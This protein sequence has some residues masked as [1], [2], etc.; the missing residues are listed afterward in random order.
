MIHH[1]THGIGKIVCAT[2]P[3][4]DGSPR[5]IVEWLDGTESKVI[6]RELRPYV[7][8]GHEEAREVI[9]NGDADQIVDAIREWA[10]CEIAEI[11]EDGR[12][13]IEGPQRG[14]WLDDDKLQVFVAWA[15]SQES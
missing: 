11:D 6:E 5:V 7:R 4:A 8:L 15:K 9:R 12:I 1:P 13:W 3:H 10:N 2:S 14:H